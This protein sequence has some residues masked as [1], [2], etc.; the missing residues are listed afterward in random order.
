M[1]QESERAVFEEL[2]RL[3]NDLV[4]LQ[5]ETSKKN[6]EMARLAAIVESSAEAIF[7]VDLEGVI[8]SWN[9]A[10]EKLY[11][12][13][14]A[15]MVGRCGAHLALFARGESLAGILEQ[16]R[17]GP[18]VDQIEIDLPALEAAAPPPTGS[19]E[20]PPQQLS[21]SG[22]R[23][24]SLS[25]S[26][27]RDALGNLCGLSCFGRDVTARKNTERELAV[28]ESKLKSIFDTM[29]DGYLEAFLDGPTTVVNPAAVR[30]LGYADAAELMAVPA[31]RLFADKEE[32]SRLRSVFDQGGKASSEATR[33]KLK[34]GSVRVF[35]GSV[36]LVTPSEGDPPSIVMMFRDVMD[37]VRAEREAQ[38]R[39]QAE[40][41]N[42]LKGEFLANMSHE[43]RT[44]MHAVLGLT[45][46][47]LQTE[48]DDRQR[49][50]LSKIQASGRALLRIVNDI[51]D[52]SKVEAGKLELEEVSFE[53][54][55]VIDT[56][57]STMADKAAEK[58]IELLV[59]VAP[60]VS[61]SLRGDPVRLG[62]VLLNLVSNG[63]KFT[64]QG[65]VQ[66]IVANESVNSD[67]VELRFSVDDTGSGIDDDVIPGLFEAFSQADTSITRKFGG[68]GLGLAICRRLVHLM[69]G[70]IEV[71]SI[72][73]RGS[74]FT[75]T[76]IFG[77]VLVAEGTISRLAGLRVLILDE[78]QAERSALA[79][80]LRRI[81]LEVAE[82]EP[83]QN[84]MRVIE[85][86]DPPFR[87]IFVSSLDS[88][89]LLNRSL[90][91][92]SRLAP[93]VLVADHGDQAV[94]ARASGQ[95]D[96][97][98]F[99]PF[100]ASHLLDTVLS[101][102]GEPDV[103]HR[104]T[105]PSPRRELNEA[106]KAVQGARVLVVED[107]RI[108]QQIARELLEN[109]GLRVDIADNGQEAVEKVL[110][111]PPGTWDLVLMDL[112]MPIMDG[113]EATVT[114]RDHKRY[115]RLPILAMTAHVLS[116]ERDRCYQAGMDDCISKP[117]DPQQFFATLRH[118]IPVSRGRQDEPESWDFPEIA[119]VDSRL[120]LL[121]VA[122]NRAL[123][124]SLLLDLACQHQQTC[125]ELEAALVARDAPRL[126]QLS[127]A[128]RGVAG[129]LGLLAVHQLCTEVERQSSQSTV[130]PDSVHQ[131]LNEYSAVSQL[132]L[133]S[134]P[135]VSAAASPVVTSVLSEAG[136][137]VLSCLEEQLRSSDGAALA[138]LP[139]A[140]R[141]L[142]ELGRASEADRLASLVQ[143]LELEQALLYL[144]GLSDL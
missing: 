111:N 143:Q 79:Q 33:L 34:D 89:R 56:L 97:V 137:S 39:A 92:A 142:N 134:L 30:I 25:Y 132:I 76:A 90:G 104:A 36:R 2:S 12:H 45:H 4:N 35:E 52:F 95:V 70:Q 110:G 29:E 46:L 130:S 48:L 131:L 82:E 125:A 120:G 57:I 93:L 73:G 58:G 51:L 75:F 114:I 87:A 3:N 109:A 59:S 100:A 63:V 128:L 28:S 140:V 129:N 144:K 86:A 54:D 26:P 27:V 69:H 65:K 68:T 71:R 32:R 44:P 8:I 101:L 16:M 139:E 121:R 1:R 91:A 96:R 106:M 21:D 17:E 67:S 18:P 15:E 83:D 38:A 103:E 24:I 127:H 117:L 115:A 61:A 22:M 135:V 64:E 138:T 122:G 85:E 84:A 47:A 98:L 105:D 53:L 9:Q 94:A 20:E 78:N 118:W 49:D 11:G 80:A 37:R 77:R 10:A 43:I 108:N 141:V 74:T 123:Y 107:N 40:A 7:S 6:V 88:I 5:R 116:Q 81:G 41:A 99:K 19:A 72:S 13:L 55:E 42:R 113:Y 14:R 66:V 60:D 126:R 133:H 23:K 31:R 50:Y 124:R 102:L 136:R 119:G 62:Q 112:Q